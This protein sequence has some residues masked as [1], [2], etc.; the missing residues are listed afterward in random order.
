MCVCL[1]CCILFRKCH[2]TAS[3]GCPCWTGLSNIEC[4]LCRWIAFVVMLPCCGAS[5][6]PCYRLWYCP[7]A[8]AVLR[9]DLSA[10][11]KWRNCCLKQN[12]KQ[13]KN[14]RLAL[15]DNVYREYGSLNWNLSFRWKRDRE[16]DREKVNV[17]VYA[18]PTSSPMTVRYGWN[19]SML[20]FK[21]ELFRDA[22]VCMPSHWINWKYLCESILLFSRRFHSGIRHSGIVCIG[23]VHVHLQRWE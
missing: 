14:E 20:L 1:P 13:S 17:Y 4:E 11:V 16:T 5:S 10:D 6:L 12:E 15:T 22:F 23:Q 2:G 18:D 9:K 21:W 7:V 19:K 3:A 8:T